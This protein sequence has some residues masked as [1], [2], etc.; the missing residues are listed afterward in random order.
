L[1]VGDGA[2]RQFQLVKTYGAGTSA[3]RRPIRKPVAGTAIIAVDGLVQT[4]GTH[5]ALDAATGLVTFHSDFLP[6]QGSLIT[7]GFEFDTPVR[8]DTDFLEISLSDAKAG[9]IPDIPIVEIRI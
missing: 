9:R 3:Y 8:F 2:T 7:A 6:P 5:V 1:G 4:E